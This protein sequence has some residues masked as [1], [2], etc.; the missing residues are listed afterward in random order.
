MLMNE[1]RQY[2][3]EELNKT[4]IV[5][6]KKLSEKYSVTMETIR[7]DLDDI[8]AETTDI[9]KVYGGALKSSSVDENYSV[10]DE[11]FSNEKDSLGKKAAE[12][13]K[14]DDCIFLDAGSTITKI[15]PH[16]K[17]KNN[18]KIVTVSL[19]VLIEFTKFFQ[20]T[21]CTHKIFFIG[22]EVK[23]NLLSTSGT[24]VALSIKNYFFNKAFLTLDG[25]SFEKGITSH[26][27]DEAHVTAEVLKH[28]SKNIFMITEEKFNSIKFFKVC[29]LDSVHTIIADNPNNQFLKEISQNFEINI[30]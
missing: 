20:N 16:L 17:S 24:E 7:K 9:K 13:I 23:L 30:Y 8:I 28:C 3:L 25:I 22:G 27:Y 12:L 21:N 4:N 6:V 18:L 10:R 29:N 19:A 5:Y 1:R 2:I 14:D 15:I 26:N 11:L